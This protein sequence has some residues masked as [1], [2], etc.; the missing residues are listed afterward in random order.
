MPR[1]P[2]LLASGDDAYLADRVLR[3]WT[4]PDGAD[5]A[6]ADD[7]VAALA[8][9]E[10]AIGA[11]S[12]AAGAPGIMHQVVGSE[13]PLVGPGLP[14]RDRTYEVREF[15]T[16]DEYAGMVRAVL[17]KIEAGVVRKVV[18]G[19]CVD[20]TS[21]PPLEPADV[22]DR[23]LQTRPGRYVFSVPLTA[24]LEDGPLLVGAS[25][26][27]LVSREGDRIAC[28]PLA[29]SVPR[30]ADPAE[31]ERRAA[32]L[33]ASE[34]DLAEH[35]FVVDA[36]VSALKE[37]CVD[38][39]AAGRTHAAVDRHPVAPR[40]ADHGPAGGPGVGPERPQ[41]GPDAAPDPRRG[42]GAGRR[43]GGGDRRPRGRPARLLRRLRR[44]GRRLRR[45][46]LRDHHPRRG[47]RRRPAPAVRRRGH[48]GRLRP[49]ARGARDRRQARDDDAGHRPGLSPRRGSPPV[50]HDGVTTR[51]V[52]LRACFRHHA[53]RWPGRSRGSPYRKRPRAASASPKPEEPRGRLDPGMD[54]HPRRHRRGDRDRPR[55]HRP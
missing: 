49:R 8:P 17:D 2:L 16:A 24:S 51:G 22:I 29:G 28:T 40:L 21:D 20:V 41:A 13:R 36:I 5:E 14:V 23:L 26:E 33:R 32:G 18:L 44:L 39:G 37:V 35:A 12:F 48:R 15:P 19:R 31:D 30:A 50:W 55:R 27:L 25:P 52:F 45:R 46:R 43:R 6:W 7:V 54:H 34:K 11:L 3:T 53:R 38:D 4:T 47:D 9:G 10:R 1:R 42:R